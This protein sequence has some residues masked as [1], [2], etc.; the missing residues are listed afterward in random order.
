MGGSYIA[1]LTAFYVDD[2]PRLPLWQLLP[3]DLLVPAR[4]C[5]PA[6]DG[7]LAALRCPHLMRERFV[8]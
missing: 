3:P 5:R 6:A 4:C 7:V 1:M 2:G 8:E